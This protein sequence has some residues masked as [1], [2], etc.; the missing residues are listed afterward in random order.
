MTILKKSSGFTLVELMVVVAIIG[1][2]AATAIPAFSK[3]MNDAKQSEAK[4]NMRS[5]GD[6]AIAYFNTEHFYG[7]HRLT[8]IRGIYP[9]CPDENNDL[10]PCARE[11][12]LICGATRE[13]EL[14]VK[15]DPETESIANALQSPPWPELGFTLSAPFY[16]CYTYF[17]DGSPTKF[18]MEAHARFDHE[19]KNDSNFEMTGDAEGRL[20][21]ILPPEDNNN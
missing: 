14:G 12:T 15:M 16:Y 18:H 4:E 6:R 19:D 21:P 2:L 17:N 10:K 11:E 8:R 13:P 3:Y 20:S 5:V 1:I 9:V 7:P